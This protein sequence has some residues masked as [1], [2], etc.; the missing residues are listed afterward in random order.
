MKEGNARN[1]GTNKGLEVRRKERVRMKK[2]RKEMKG[3]KGG[4]RRRRKGEGVS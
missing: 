1:E 4:Q 2:G 3:M